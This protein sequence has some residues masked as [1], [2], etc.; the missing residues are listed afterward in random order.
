MVCVVDT[1][2]MACI[3]I[4]PIIFQMKP[5]LQQQKS[6]K[7]YKNGIPFLHFLLLETAFCSKRKTYF[8]TARLDQRP[9]EFNLN[10]PVQ[11]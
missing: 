7:P 8:C 6:W 1:V 11:L 3:S 2:D 10:A 9:E 5:Q 4:L